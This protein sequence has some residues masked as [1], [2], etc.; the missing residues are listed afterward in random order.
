MAESWYRAMVWNLRTNTC[1]EGKWKADPSHSLHQAELPSRG[2]NRLSE[3]TCWSRWFLLP[4]YQ[5]NF[6]R[7]EAGG[8]RADAQGRDAPWARSMI[9]TAQ[10][11]PG[12]DTSLETFTDKGALGYTASQQ[13]PLQTVLQESAEHAR[14]CLPQP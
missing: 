4:S 3:A 5:R 9:H 6:P 2:Q 14:G 8:D 1:Q 13:T 10:P 12:T 7:G 11:W